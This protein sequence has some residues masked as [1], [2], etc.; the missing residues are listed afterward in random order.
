MKKKHT[1]GG[2]ARCSWRV[3]VLR[4]KGRGGEKKISGYK[5][6]TQPSI[7]LLTCFHPQRGGTR[8][9]TGEKRPRLGSAFGK[10]KECF[11][12]YKAV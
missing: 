3:V 5:F 4:V 2:P 8:D 10:E 11:D 7:V 1:Y 9:C 6:D 12:S